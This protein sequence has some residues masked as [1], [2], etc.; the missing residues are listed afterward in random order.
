M[1][2]LKSHIAPANDFLVH[3]LFFT[4]CQPPGWG[5]GV[6]CTYI[7]LSEEQTEGILYVLDLMVLQEP[8]WQS[9]VGCILTCFPV[10]ASVVTKLAVSDGHHC[11]GAVPRAPAGNPGQQAV[12]KRHVFGKL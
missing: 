4:L 5:G 2:P 6:C 7:F 1:F 8:K 11:L 9:G 10:Q 3:I 12:F